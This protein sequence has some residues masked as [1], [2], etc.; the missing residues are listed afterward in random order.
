MQNLEYQVGVL[1]SLLQGEQHAGRL[2]LQTVWL[3]HTIPLSTNYRAAHS[4]RATMTATEFL[5]EQEAET[6]SSS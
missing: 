2:L 6:N 1:T 5:Q 3:L 4:S